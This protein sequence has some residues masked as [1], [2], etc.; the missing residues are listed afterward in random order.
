MKRGRD[1]KRVTKEKIK[2]KEKKDGKERSSAPAGTPFPD[3]PRALL[4]DFDSSA[5]MKKN[6]NLKRRWTLKV[7]CHAI[8]WFFAPF[9]CGEK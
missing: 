6:Y 9:C 4:E 7:H 1:R 3:I 5:K 2:N 8:Q